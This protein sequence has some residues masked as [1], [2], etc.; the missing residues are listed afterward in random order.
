MLAL[1]DMVS[2]VDLCTDFFDLIIEMV[3]TP[4]STEL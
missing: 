3:N 2:Q 4:R 1:L